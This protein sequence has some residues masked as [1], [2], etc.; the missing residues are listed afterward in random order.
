MRTRRNAITRNKYA[1]GG[2]I[3]PVPN[4]D[5]KCPDLPP[6][7]QVRDLSYRDVNTYRRPFTRP[8]GKVVCLSCGGWIVDK[9]GKPARP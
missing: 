5:C 9:P 6:G 1:R 2:P 4:F 3:R 7:V 8:S